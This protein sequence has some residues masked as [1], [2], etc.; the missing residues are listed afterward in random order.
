MLGLTTII[1]ALTGFEIPLLVRI[2]KKYYPLKSNLAY[3]LSLD[4]IGA[5]LATLL[6]PFLLLPFAGIFRTSLVFGLVNVL[7]GLF[8]YRFFT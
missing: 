4:Y 5:L 8:I 1:G 3:V 6:F 7:L 2:L